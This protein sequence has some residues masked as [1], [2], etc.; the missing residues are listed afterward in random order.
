MPTYDYRCNA[1]NHEFELFHSIKDKPIKKCP[2]CK[3]LT[4]ERLIGAG[5]TIIFKGSGFY[6][7]DYRSDEYKARVKAETSSTENKDK[8]SKKEKKEKKT[9]VKD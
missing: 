8:K 2:K 6:Q 1:C 3:K 7:T 5:S 9:D 4:V